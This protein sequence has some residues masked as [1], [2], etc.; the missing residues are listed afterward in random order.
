VIGDLDYLEVAFACVVGANRLEL[1]GQA[2]R[3]PQFGLT[4]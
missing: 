2:P 4:V 1:H 3:F